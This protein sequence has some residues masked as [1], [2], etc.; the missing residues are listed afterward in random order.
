MILAI[1]QGTTGVACLVFDEH[2]RV[3]TRAYREIAQHFPAP[4]WVEHDLDDIRRTVSELCGH[5]LEQAGCRPG[6][7]RAIGIANQRETICVWDPRTGEPLH[8]A[9]V[10][11]DR[12]TASRC[13]ELREAGVERHVRERTG[14]EI[15]RA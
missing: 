12:R 2:A 10:W 4:G 3:V 8:R 14:L 1:D 15:G 7:L 5:V 13:L 9:I 11:Q 6:A